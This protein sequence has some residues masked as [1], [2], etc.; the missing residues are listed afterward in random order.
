M[1]MQRA[2]DVA[3]D[4]TP[5]CRAPGR[6]AAPPPAV[7]I[8]AWHACQRGAAER[9]TGLIPGNGL[10]VP[11]GLVVTVSGWV[12]GCPGSAPEHFLDL[13]GSSGSARCR[14]MLCDSGGGIWQACYDP[15]CSPQP[16]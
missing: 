6:L 5:I 10:R 4:D 2:V 1:R 12:L 8:A 15:I 13:R 7:E 9:G 16:A 11:R 3:V 14:L